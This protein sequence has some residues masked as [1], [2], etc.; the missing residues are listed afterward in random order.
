MDIGTPA[1]NSPRRDTGPSARFGIG[2]TVFVWN[3]AGAIPG[4]VMMRRSLN[5]TTETGRASVVLW[6]PALIAYHYGPERLA[7]SRF[8][9]KVIVELFPANGPRVGNGAFSYREESN[10][11]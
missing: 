10:P 3:R 8:H 9:R 1:R 6:T 2:T 11:E 5:F 4:A 7:S